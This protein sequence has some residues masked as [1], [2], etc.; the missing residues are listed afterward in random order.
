MCVCVRG[1]KAKSQPNGDLN[2][3][4]STIV[5]KCVCIKTDM[6]LHVSI[7]HV[8]VMYMS[9]VCHVYVMYMSC[10]CHVYVHGQAFLTEHLALLASSHS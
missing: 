7:C 9:C 1:G 8:Y 6:C 2:L 10:V 5:H 3:A 4:E